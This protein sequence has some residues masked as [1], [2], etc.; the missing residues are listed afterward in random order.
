MVTTFGYIIKSLK[1]TPVSMVKWIL[2]L[3]YGKYFYSGLHMTLE[4]R[5]PNFGRFL[6][7]SEYL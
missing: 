3:R 4:F 1:E 7:A 2:Q 6:G 5:P